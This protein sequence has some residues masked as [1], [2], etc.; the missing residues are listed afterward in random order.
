MLQSRISSIHTTKKSRFSILGGNNQLVL[1]A[2]VILVIALLYARD[3]FGYG[4]G[5]FTIL[6]ATVLPAV[7][8]SPS[9][10]VYYILFLLPL[11]SGLPGNYLWPLLILLLVLK[12]PGNIDSR[13]MYCFILI[14]ALEVLH[15]GFYTFH[16]D[17]SGLVGYLSTVFLLCYI[18]TLKDKEVNNTKCV[19]F[20]VL[21]VFAFLF[22]IWFIT[23]INHNA[24]MLLEEGGRLGYTK[25]ISG[26]DDNVMMLNA[27]PNGLGYYSLIGLSLSFML[28]S[29]RKLGLW[30]MLLLSAVFVYVGAMSVSRTWLVGMVF[31]VGLLVFFN[32]N[33]KLHNSGIRNI[34]LLILVVIGIYALLRN[35]L[36]YQAFSNRLS[37]DSLTTAGSRTEIFKQYNRF[38]FDHPLYLLF[39]AGAVH[40]HDVINEVFNATHNGTQQVVASY[41]LVGLVALVIMFIKG[42]KSNYRKGFFIC[43]IPLIVAL[44]Y[45]QAGQLLNPHHNLYPFIIGFVALRLTDDDYAQN[46]Q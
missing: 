43:A 8:M 20:F 44:F 21:G 40:Y 5:K 24:E 1:I 26:S 31:L 39:G 11:A 42:F 14:A 19:L 45:V 41:G 12:K 28:Y 27:N 17:M 32:R 9:S 46:N 33:N 6:G 4:L 3:L 13:G 30:Q 22:A 37:D 34:V 35:E 38:F 25:S 7:L 29:L 23:Q 2:T 10:L 15:F 36:I 16:I 18:T